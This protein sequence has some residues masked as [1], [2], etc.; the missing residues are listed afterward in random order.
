MLTTFNPVL[1]L[2]AAAIALVVILSRLTARARQIA[3]SSDEGGLQPS[4]PTGYE[5]LSREQRIEYWTYKLWA[6]ESGGPN[7]TDD[8]LFDQE[9]VDHMRSIDIA[10]DD[11]LPETLRRLANLQCRSSAE[12]ITAFNQRTGMKVVYATEQPHNHRDT[13]L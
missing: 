5:K 2:A 13:S 1:T 4:T 3:S 9:L 11:I 6:I 12:V 10:I 7:G 8:S